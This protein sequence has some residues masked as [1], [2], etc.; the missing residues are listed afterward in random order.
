MGDDRGSAPRARKSMPG[1]DFELVS[2]SR[3][4]NERA[5]GEIVRRY[6]G[7]IRSKSRFYFLSGAEK[8]DI[9]QEGMIGLYKAIRDYDPDRE[10]G[11]R[12]FAELC[13]TRQMIS[14]VK[15]STRLKHSPMSGYVSLSRTVSGDE[16]GERL[17]GDILAVRDICDPA[18]IVLG[19]WEGEFIRRG[20]IESLSPF[21]K[22]VLCH[23]IGGESYGD[24]AKRLGRST[25][26]IDNALQRIR[27]KVEIQVELCHMC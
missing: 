9:I 14:A 17:F 10:A 3:S 27:K 11:F 2:A 19:A 7:L 25:K 13:I 5:T 18:A 15:A 1:D 8:D 22:D 20:L 24:I 4:G 23:Y 21:E 16:E 6:R 12:S 26:A